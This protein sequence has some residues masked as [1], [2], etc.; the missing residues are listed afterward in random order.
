RRNNEPRQMAAAPVGT[1]AVGNLLNINRL[2]KQADKLFAVITAAQLCSGVGGYNCRHHGAFDQ[3]GSFVRG[4]SNIGLV[5]VNPATRID[6]YLHLKSA[7]G[8]DCLF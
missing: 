1:I 4:L 3:V 5:E 7:V 6:G 8:T 2:L